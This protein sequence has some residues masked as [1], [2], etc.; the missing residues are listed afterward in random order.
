M[1][2][3]MR[4]KSHNMCYEFL[5]LNSIQQKRKLHAGQNPIDSLSSPNVV[6]AER[7]PLLMV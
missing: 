6:K 3:Q 1:F 4:V 5:S 7:G 2:Q